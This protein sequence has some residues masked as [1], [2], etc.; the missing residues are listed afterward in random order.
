M[1][2][3]HLLIES[4]LPEDLQDFERIYTAKGVGQLLSDIAVNYPDQYN[5]ISQMI[6][7][8][9]RSATYYQ[10]ETIGLEDVKPLFDKR[11]ILDEMDKEI[12]KISKKDPE[13]EQKRELLWHTPHD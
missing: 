13:Y 11:P 7:D 2:A 10:G 3:V 9:G 4:Q 8:T 1:K 6:A 5:D 12:K